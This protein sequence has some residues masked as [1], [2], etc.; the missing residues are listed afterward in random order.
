[1]VGALSPTDAVEDVRVVEDVAVVEDGAV[2]VS[3]TTVVDEGGG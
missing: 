3:A 1:L 2:E